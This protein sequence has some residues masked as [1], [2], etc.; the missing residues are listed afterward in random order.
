MLNSVYGL[1]FSPLTSSAL[2]SLAA[3]HGLVQST[4]F[5]DNIF[6]CLSREVVFFLGLSVCILVTDLIDG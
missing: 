6:S 2:S 4:Y 1:V 5:P 3:V